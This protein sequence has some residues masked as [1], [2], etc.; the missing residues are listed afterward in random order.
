MAPLQANIIAIRSCW[1]VAARVS[2]LPAVS[3][4]I[5]SRRQRS[6]SKYGCGFGAALTITVRPPNGSISKPAFS[7]IVPREST[8]EY[9]AGLSRS[10]IGNSSR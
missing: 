1:L 2:S 7:N 3:S 8:T 4:E 5:I 10:V 6:V 9:S